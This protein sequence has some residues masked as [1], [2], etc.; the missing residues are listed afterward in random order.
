MSYYIQYII[1]VRICTPLFEKLEFVQESYVMPSYP[2][3]M[4]V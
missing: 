2:E 4:N 3:C 1:V